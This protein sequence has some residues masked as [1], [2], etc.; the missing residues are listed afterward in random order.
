VLG[1]L[2]VL[3][4]DAYPPFSLADDPDYPGTAARAGR[5]DR[6]RRASVIPVAPET[7][8]PTRAAMATDLERTDPECS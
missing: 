3:M 2:H 8:A 4:T 7:E 1:I 6:G 5:T